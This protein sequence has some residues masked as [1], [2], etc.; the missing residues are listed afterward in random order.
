VSSAQ[1]RT[2][3][4]ICPC[5]FFPP[6]LDPVLDRGT[7]HTHAVIA[8][9][10]PAGGTGGQAVFSH[11]THRQLRAPMGGVTAGR[12]HIAQSDVEM[13]MPWCTIVRGVRHQE[14]NRATGVDL[15]QVVHRTLPRWMARGEMGASWAGGVRLVTAVWH[16]LRR[17]EVLDVDNTRCRVWQVFTRSEHTWLPGEKRVGPVV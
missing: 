3:L 6:S 5:A 16:Q 4:P 2:V 7:G 15:A 10:M 17:W 8:P 14:V 9:Q 11:E 1:S 12:G 13:R